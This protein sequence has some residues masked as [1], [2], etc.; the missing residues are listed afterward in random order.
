[1]MNATKKLTRWDSLSEFDFKV[2]HRTSVKRQEAHALSSSHNTRMDESPLE[3]DIP[4][5]RKTEA[6]L[7]AGRPKQTQNLA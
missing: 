3:D 4:V 7:D 1:M 6:Q 2:V 5:L